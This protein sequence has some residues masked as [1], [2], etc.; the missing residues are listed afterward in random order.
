MAD[1]GR[2]TLAPINDQ[3]LD[4][5]K[6]LEEYKNLIKYKLNA[7]KLEEIIKTEDD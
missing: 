2:R 4:K 5:E 3:S 1:I 6:L 7:Y